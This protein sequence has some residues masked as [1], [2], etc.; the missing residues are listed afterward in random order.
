MTA[1]AVGV[2]VGVVALVAL[3][4]VLAAKG[5]EAGKVFLYAAVFVAIGGAVEL[6]SRRKKQRNARAFAQPPRGPRH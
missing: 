6:N 4:V 2:A 5:S 3:A 1:V